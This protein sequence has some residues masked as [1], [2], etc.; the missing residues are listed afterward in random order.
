VKPTPPAPA[1]S[2]AGF[3]LADVA[4]VQAV[5]KGE[6]SPEQQKRAMDWVIKSAANVPGIS[7]RA[8]DPHATSFLEGRRFVGAQILSLLAMNL[9][10]LRAKK[11][12]N[13]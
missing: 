10:T 9:S 1:D 4:A 12:T 7:F 5:Y 2:P 3:A 11:A 13:G 6:G 8:G